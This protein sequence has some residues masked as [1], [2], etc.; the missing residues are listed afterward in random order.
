MRP[1]SPS[2]YF[3]LDS[4]RAA[5]VQWA[6]R[7]LLL[8]AGLLLVVRPADATFPYPSPP[9]GTPPQDYAS[10]LR[11][12]PGVPATPNDFT[13]GTA[14]KLGSGTTGDPVI[15]SKPD[16]LFGVTG[17]SVDR[18]WQTTTGRPDVVLAILDSGIIWSDAGDMQQL[19]RKVR[20]NRR[21]L[22]LPQ[23]A[24]GATKPQLAVSFQN[25]DP[26]DLNDDGVFEVTDYANDPRVS[27]RNGNG[28]LDPQDLIIQFSDGTDA[29]ANGFID[30]IAGWNFLDDDNDPFD[31]VKYGHGTGEA[32]DSSAEADNGGDLGSCPNCMFVPLRVG[33]SFVGDSNLFAQAVIYAVDN[34]VHV[35]QEALGSVNN[36]AFARRAIDYAYAHDVPVI[37]SAADE[38]SFHHNVPAANAHTI[39]VNSVTRYGDLSGLV[40]SPRSYLYLNGCTNYGGNM[41]VAISSTACSSEATGR[42]AGIA[43]LIISAALNAVDAGTLLPRRTD[44]TGAVH[45]LSANEVQQLLTMTADDIDFTGDR[46]VDFAIDLGTFAFKST[47]FAS[48]AGW[49][50]FFGYGRANAQRAVAAAGAAT[51][52]PEADLTSPEWWTTLDPVT[53]PAVTVRGSTRASRASDYD[54]ELA[55]GCGVQPLDDSFTAINAATGVSQAI[56]DTTLGTWSI[57]AA[58]AQCGIDPSAVAAS[59]ISGAASP[60]ATPDQFTVTLRLRVTDANGRRAESRRTVYLHHDPDLL[61]GFP[62]SIVDSGEP[63]PAFVNL[64]R[65]VRGRGPDQVGRQQLLVPT[66]GGTVMALRE[67]G[68]S[69]PGWPVQVDRL[70]LHTGA[71][72]FS[73]G[74]VSSDYR[75]SLG[76]GLAVGD[77]DGDGWQEVVGTTLAGKLYVW[78]RRGNRRPGFPVR[79]NPVFSARSAR[80]RYNRLQPGII[81]APVLA[82]LDGDGTLEIV[83]GAMDRHVYAWR[84]DGSL[85]PGW[86]VLAVDRTQ[87]SAI[88]PVSHKVTP[89]VV[90]GQAVA[91]QGT[92]IVSTPAIGPLRGDGKP[93]VVL[94]TNEEYREAPAFSAT[95]HQAASLLL[96]LGVFAKANGRIY[97]IPAGGNADASVASNPSGP[98]LSGWPAKIAVLRDELLPWIEGVPGSPALADVDGDGKLEVGISGVV[99]P[100]YLLKAD[101]TSFF[102]NGSDG[103]PLTFPSDKAAFGARTNSIDGPSFPALGSGSFAR[104]DGTLAFFT[105]GGG[106]GRLLDTAVPAEQL[107][108]DSHLLVWNAKT[109]TMLPGFPR[110]VDDMQFLTNPTAADIDGDRRPELLT[111]SGGY[112]VH[113]F[114]SEGTEAAGWPKFTGGWLIASPTVGT[115]GARA[116]VAATTR[117]G[118]LYVWR[119]RG[120]IA[121]RPWARFHHDARNTGWYD[122]K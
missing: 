44:P 23:T 118:Q 41:A 3:S 49:D 13:G 20:L 98:Y 33:D 116:A 89:N 95:G 109:R 32:Q 120:Q 19:R 56:D 60:N 59:A 53:S 46:A 30:D 104:L 105:P 93:V 17:M 79:T 99:G 65:R 42:G 67:T 7:F 102:G 82:D 36:T 45:P 43:G 63:S 103:L 5:G 113:A 76:N 96:T 70:P 8:F 71:P 114:S 68:R 31:E 40:M 91:L 26:Y 121:D 10:Y 62:L 51:I 110:V 108:H 111:G 55:Y 81:G 85:Q 107:A 106:L 2:R 4:A 83:A 86:P 66:T 15:D 58:A 29:D 38:E 12:A 84:H 24:A 74:E 77:L 80:D 101:G 78:D 22:P 122:G 64:R 117:E 27:D 37:A 112:L 28:L 47:R 94:T 21:E 11:L 9:P 57:Q 14:W 87:M 18:A 54:W 88:D 35:V 69:L 92:K 1:C 16:E 115:F 50:Q 73:S 119:A 97:A 61:R 75:E 90:G 34:G 48:Q 6:V 72:A 100:A 52:P 25:P 39:V